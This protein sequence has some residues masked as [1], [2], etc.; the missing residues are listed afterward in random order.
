MA[1]E[2]PDCR[3]VTGND[4][5]ARCVACGRTLYKQK[6]R[7][8]DDWHILAVSVLAGVLLTIFVVQHRC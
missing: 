6:P 3:T 7:P 1:L 5:A 4:Q 8:T 2:C